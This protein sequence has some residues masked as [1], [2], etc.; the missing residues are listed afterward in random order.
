MW[1][2]RHDVRGGLVRAFGRAQVGPCEQLGATFIKVGQI[3]STRGDLL[4][5]E[6]VDEFP[7][8]RDQVPPFPFADVQRVAEPSLGS[9]LAAVDVNF[10][11]EPVTAASVAPVH[12]STSSTGSVW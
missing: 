1:R 2:L 12:R 11:R 3:T 9:P 7:E 6:A 8:L 5:P 10:E 4:P